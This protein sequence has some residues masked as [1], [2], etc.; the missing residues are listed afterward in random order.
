MVILSGGPLGGA[1]I[2][3]SGWEIGARMYL[4]TADGQDVTYWRYDEYQAIYE[5]MGKIQ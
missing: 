5:G 3:A 2:D 4:I 1:E